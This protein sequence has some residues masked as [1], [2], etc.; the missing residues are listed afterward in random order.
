MVEFARLT[1]ALDGNEAL[2]RRARLAA[3]SLTVLSG[4]EAI[5]VDVG[6]RIA[7]GR[8][9]APSAAF[10]LGATPDAWEEFAKPGALKLDFVF[11]V[12]DNAANETCP[13]WPGQ[14]MT[15]HWGV[16]RCGR[17]LS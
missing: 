5:S 1:D 4:E 6:E 2:R 8:G 3:L 16:G 15:A 12:C 7:V 17:V 11:T 9:V 13:V 14:P 10:S